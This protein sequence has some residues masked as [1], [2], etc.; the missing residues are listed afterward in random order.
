MLGIGS[1]EQSAAPKA[2]LAIC[3]SYVE[4][5]HPNAV[6]FARERMSGS[7]PAISIPLIAIKR[8]AIVGHLDYKRVA[9][10]KKQKRFAERYA[11]VPDIDLNA[12]RTR[13]VID[14]IEIAVLLDRST[15]FQWI[16][17]AIKPIIGRMPYV[18]SL[19]AS[20]NA[21]SNR[22]VITIQEPKISRVYTA[23]EVLNSKLTVSRR[24]V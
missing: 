4:S 11:L 19:F 13:A 21:A 2:I 1:Q 24:V 23:M 14:W 20:P 10:G 12:F 15:Q 17:Q 9:L 6:P 3:A 22:F 5:R 18:K 16:Q 8:P 7:K